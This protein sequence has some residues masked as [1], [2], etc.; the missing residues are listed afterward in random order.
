MKDTILYKD[1]NIEIKLKKDMDVTDL[2]TVAMSCIEAGLI[3]MK[4]YCH[5]AKQP[6]ELRKFCKKDILEAV[7]IMEGIIL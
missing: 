6:M 1:K 3:G 4:S 5:Q 2:P 7:G